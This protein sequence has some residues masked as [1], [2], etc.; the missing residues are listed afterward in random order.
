MSDRDPVRLIIGGQAHQEWDSYRIDSDIQTPSDDWQVNASY[1]S[2]ATGDDLLPEFI[3]EGARVQVMLGDDQ[4][5]EGLIDTVAESVDRHS[6]GFEL[7]GRDR[8]SLLLDCSAPMLSMQLATLEQI[9]NKAV[10]PLGIKTVE[11]RAKPAAPR[12]RVHTEPGQSVWEWL[13]AACEANSVWP[14]FSPDGKLIIGAPDYTTAPVADLILRRSG[15]GNNV[16]GIWRTRS[17]Q[18]AYSEI[19]VLGQSA[20]D[21]DEVGHHNIRGVVKDATMPLYRPLVV[22]DGNCESVELATRR[23]SKLMADSKMGRD[24]MMIRVAGHRITT[25]VGSGRPWA[26][27]MRVHVISDKH[28]VDAV[29]FIMRRVFTRS[30]A[31]GMTTELELVPDGVWLLN[32]PF[33]KAARRSNSGKRRGHYGAGD[34]G[35]DVSD[36]DE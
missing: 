31:A 34:D 10:K 3:Y 11:Y 22:I 24:R 9:I 35:D 18:N 27:G 14:W 30:R 29:Y 1:G 23:A 8:A 6:V 13:Q 7:Y 28:R 33:I 26:A 5:L 20:G 16:L 2:Q 25:S 32:L 12:Q 15:E 4:I 17:M 21:G 36:G 19:T